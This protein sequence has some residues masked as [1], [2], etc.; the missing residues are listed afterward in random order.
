MTAP[1][2][3]AVRTRSRTSDA[4]A[5]TAVAE[6]TKQVNELQQV[7]ND[8]QKQ[9]GANAFRPASTMQQFMHVPFDIFVLDLALLGGMP[10]SMI[11]MIYG[12]ES[13]GKSTTMM[14]AIAALQRL[15]PHRTVALIEPEGTFDPLWARTQGVNIDTLLIGQPDTGEQAVD[16]ACAALE[17]RETS[18]L[19]LDS[20]AALMPAKEFAKS[21]ED[22][23]VAMQAKLV[24]RFVRKAMNILI[25]ERKRD[26]YPALFLVNQ[27]RNKIQM[28]GDPRTLPG[29]NALKFFVGVRWEILN[30]E[31]VGVDARG[32]EIVDYNTHTIRITKNK[33]GNSIRTAEFTMIRNPNHPRGVGFIDEAETVVTYARNF[34]KVTGGGSSWR[35]RDFDQKFG[36][37]RD[38]GEFL[39]DN[40]EELRRLKHEII[41]EHRVSLG[42]RAD[43]WLVREV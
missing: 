6:A 26:H 37:L 41:S 14:R 11:S 25:T 3:A 40:P 34:G 27:W 30:Q 38:M 32:T 31:K 23:I 12:W 24:G 18:M 35:I 33:T 8:F 19:C 20:I 15:M 5:A 28:M 22:E 39:Y 29:G 7:M 10:L 43:D 42:L 1:A 36:R 13:G 4:K 2:S 16:L 17:A 9:N 21:A